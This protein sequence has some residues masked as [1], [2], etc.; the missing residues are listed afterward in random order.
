MTPGSPEWLR[1]LSKQFTDETRA[2]LRT[3]A[4]ELERHRERERDREMDA[5]GD[6]L[7][8]GD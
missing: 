6:A 1:D 8:R 7:D 2:G 5:K 4:D 3:A